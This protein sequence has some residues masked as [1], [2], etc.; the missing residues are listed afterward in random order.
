[1]RALLTS[2]FLFLYIYALAQHPSDHYKIYWNDTLIKGREQYLAQNI[3]TGNSAQQPNIIIIMADD[4]G[5]TDI[6]L[7]GSKRISTP[8]IDAIGLNGV[9]FQEA[10]ITSPVCS[11]SRAGLLTGRYQQRFG[12][13][14]QMSDRYAHNVFEYLIPKLLPVF[15]PISPVWNRYYPSD[16]D[17]MRQGLPPSEITLAEVLKVNGYTTGIVGKWHLGAQDF[18]LACNRGFDYQYGFNEAFT[19]YM[20]TE[21]PEIVNGKVKGQFMDSHQWRTAEG[22]TGNCAITRNCCEK[23]DDPDYLTDRLTTEAIH[24][25]TSNKEQP[26]FLYLPYNA[27]HA[28][29]QAPADYYAQFA[30]VED[31]IQRTYLAMIKSLD[32]QIGRLTRTLDSL[33]ITENTLIFFLSDNGGAAYN[34]STDNYPYRGGKLTNFEGG[35]R[36][37]FMMQWK[38]RIP[39]GIRFPHPVSS[40]DIFATAAAAAEAT[41]PQDRVYDGINLCDFITTGN[42]LPTADNKQTMSNNEHRMSNNEQTATGI[43]L[44]TANSPLP[45]SSNPPHTALYWRSGEC[46]AIRMGE[47]KLSINTLSDINSLYNLTQDPREEHNLYEQHPEVVK[48][49]STEL[50]AWEAHMVKP[51]WP[52]VV[53]YVYKDRLGRQKFSF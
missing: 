22:R 50:A 46:K 33:G 32:D 3:K 49:L 47:W 4:L 35:I 30:H 31:H 7:Y 14:L 42:G 23:T 9:T 52:R 17:R 45:T 6:S 10:Y 51:L 29:L 39:S 2:L 41:L 11:P 18:A 40:L 5:Q 25:V 24:F 27:P 53:N 38:G 12:H 48:Q 15:R 13:E 20:D 19:L 44:P 43:L 26:F 37:P 21:A 36:V 16:E 1:M 34:G 28:P 8:N